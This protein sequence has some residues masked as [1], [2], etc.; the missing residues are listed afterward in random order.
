MRRLLASALV[1]ILSFAGALPGAFAA[2][3]ANPAEDGIRQV[4]EGDFEAALV[5]LDAAA[6]KLQTDNAPPAALARVYV[7][8]GVSYLN[9]GQRALA[10]AKFKQAV[11]LDKALRLDPQEFPPKVLNAFEAARGEVLATSS[12]EKE[13]KRGRGKTPWLLL[14]GG[15]AAAGGI[16]FF[17]T[18]SKETERVNTAPTAAVSVAPA[19]TAL[20]NATVVTFNATATDP[21]GDTL[22]YQWTFG[23]GATGTGAT[24]THVFTRT[25][26]L[27]VTLAVNDGLKTTSVSRTVVVGDLTGSW[28][29][30]STMI[31]G[32]TRLDVQQSGSRV[33]VTPYFGADR[34]GPDGSSPG[35]FDPRRVRLV[36]HEFTT[37]AV[38]SCTMTVEGPV[39]DALG[40][41]SGTAIC[42][43]SVDCPC[44]G[45]TRLVTLVRR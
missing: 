10:T 4:R 20:L 30:T 28:L 5:T 17:L 37:G 6:R 9:L 1:A 3:P 29:P 21:E 41:I 39:D 43:G 12:L 38:F 2:A 26:S 24:T 33:N 8:L 18:R 27:V 15:A 25:G 19:G 14:G 44:L 34:G 31:M 42:G 16:G 22:T 7:Y 36:Y 40:T 32:E 45:Q 13:A 11:V 35:V 23:D